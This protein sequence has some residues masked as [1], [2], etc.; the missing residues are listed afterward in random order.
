MIGLERVTQQ[1]RNG[2][3]VTRFAN[4][5][6]DDRKTGLGERAYTRMTTGHERDGENLASRYKPVKMH[7][8]RS[9][10]RRLD[11]L[12]QRTF[13]VLLILEPSCSVKIDDQMATCRPNAVAFASEIVPVEMRYVSAA[14][15]IFLLGGA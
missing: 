13:D 12:P 10:A 8:Q 3:P 5:Q 11:T 6:V 2:S 1:T 9:S 15:M 14:S 7:V 4:H